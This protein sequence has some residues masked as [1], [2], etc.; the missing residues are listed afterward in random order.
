MEW[1]KASHGG[2]SCDVGR[3][4]MRKCHNAVHCSLHTRYHLL[5][6]QQHHY[7]IGYASTIIGCSV[8]KASKIYRHISEGK[9][10]TLN[11]WMLVD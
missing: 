8:F 5:H 6:A 1:V 7:S 2:E 10:Y 11:L 4:V 3:S 9:N